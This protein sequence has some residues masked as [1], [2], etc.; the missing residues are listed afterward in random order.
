[1]KRIM[2]LL[3]ALIVI[4][5]C[6]TVSA[7]ITS[8]PLAAGET[9]QISAG[10]TDSTEKTGNRKMNVKK[11]KAIIS[12]TEEYDDGRFTV[13]LPKGWKIMTQGEY[14][15][16]CFRAWDPRN[17]NRSF[18]LFLKLEPFL[19]TKEAQQWYKR[20]A[21]GHSAYRLYADAPLMKSCTLKGFLD[22]LPATRTFAKKYY[23]AGITMNPKVLPVITKAKIVEKTKSKLPA[24]SDC[25]ENIIARITFTGSKSAR[26]EGLVTAQPRDPMIYRLGR[27]DT[28][29]Y[30][31]NLFMG[32]TAPIGELQQ[33]EETLVDCLSSFTI[34]Q[35]YANR[36]VDH[37]NQ[38]RD[39]LKEQM[40]QIEAAHDAMMAAW[41][42]RE[43]AHDIAFQ[44]QSDSILGYDRLYDKKHR[45]SV[46]RGNRF[47]RHLQAQSG[48]IQQFQSLYDR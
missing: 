9:A 27:I 26:C 39:A 7:E 3:L 16:L 22:S 5:T 35:S 6:L 34:R 10:K 44:K 33:L 24:P 46:S 20:T 8:G 4:L 41:R 29:T 31:V 28:M 2:G 40:R 30:T 18:F 23:D 37:S 48:R 45:G 21:A 43:Q 38:V 1:M 36:A 42:A 47:L 11:A 32:V 25:K 14:E 12:K 19:K 13:N 15:T 17:T